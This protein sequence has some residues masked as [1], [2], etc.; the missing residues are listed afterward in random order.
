LCN[1]PEYAPVK[2]ALEAG[3]E[4]MRKWYRKSDDTSIYFISHVLD[5][6]RKLMYLRVAWEE[7]W[8]EKG[9]DRMRKLVCRYSFAYQ[10]FRDT[11]YTSLGQSAADDWMDHMINEKA[12]QG[13]SIRGLEA[14]K[15]ENLYEELERYFHESVV[16]KRVCPDVIPW[17]GLK[18]QE[19]DYP[20]MHLM[21]RDYLAIPA[22]TCLAE[23]SFSMSALTDTARR[24]QMGTENFSALQ[25]LRAGYCDGRL[26]SI[27]EA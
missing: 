14:D 13:A 3:L 27:N 8:V 2:Q 4:N 1:I 12:Q 9:M 25:R 16:S 11:T 6:T 20:V 21:A 7:E 23:R 24:R 10:L 26:K 19:A 15:D 18:A 5:P 22:S 17:W